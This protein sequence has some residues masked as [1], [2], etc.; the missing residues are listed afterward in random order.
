MRRFSVSTAA[1]DVPFRAVALIGCASG[2]DSPVP[3]G[4]P[5]SGTGPLAGFDSAAW[6]LLL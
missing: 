1:R 6:A 2:S 4:S 3:G 5:Q